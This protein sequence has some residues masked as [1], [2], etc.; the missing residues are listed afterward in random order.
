MRQAPVSA[1]SSDSGPNRR[2]RLLRVGVRALALLAA[3]AFL[4]VLFA[5][6]AEGQRIV[7]EITESYRT[8]SLIWAGRLVRN[9]QRLFVLLA[10]FEIVASATILLLKPKRLDEAAGGFVLKILVMSVCFFAITSFELLIPNLFEGFVE[11]GRTASVVPSLNP[12]M[13]AG[14]GVGLAGKLIWGAIAGP[15]VLNPPMVMTAIVLAMLVV[16][17][18]AGIACQI[19]YTLVEGYVVMSAGVLFLGFAS[20]RGTAQLADN[21][22]TY[23]MHVGT[24]V[25]LLYMLVPIG[26]SA[27]S[28][29]SDRL[30]ASSF[31]LDLT[32]PIEAFLVVAVFC[33]LVCVLPQSFASK[34]TGGASLGIA[35]ALRNN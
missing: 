28:R 19:V 11:A 25:F 35:N 4:A 1:P 32:A 31:F 8:A 29:V 20:F 30:A 13:V 33:G 34:I 26:V 9:A 23:V 3:A 10:G 16:L 27:I 12:A 14:M 21:Y 5:P 2:A 15:M 24:K 18:F 22:I 6:E 17:C 7:N